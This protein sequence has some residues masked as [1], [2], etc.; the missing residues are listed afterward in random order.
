MAD[1]RLNRYLA[2]AG[3]GTRRS[4]ERLIASGRIAV[5]GEVVR[6]PAARVAPGVAV[7]LDGA[8]LLLREDCGVL[9]G[10]SGGRVPAIAHPGD[11]YMA[12][13]DDETA[14]LLSDEG[15]AGR[16]LRAGFDPG[17]LAGDAPEP[18]AFRPLSPAELTAAATF[19]RRARRR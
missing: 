2:L 10:L 7:T 6:E 15:L 18:G 5:G 9:V 14:V 3:M 16:L 12:G 8:R 11:L 19:A 4:V 1:V 13:H 17:R